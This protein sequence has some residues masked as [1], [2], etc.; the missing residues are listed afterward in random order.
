MQKSNFTVEE[1]EEHDLKSDDLGQHQQSRSHVLACMYPC[2][3]LLRMPLYF[4]GF[5]PQ[6][7]LPNLIMRKISDKSQLRD[8]LQNT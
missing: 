8:C 6:I 7:H 3:D 4:C 1:P 2:Y 5:I